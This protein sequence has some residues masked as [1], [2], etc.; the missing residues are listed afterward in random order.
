MNSSSVAAGT[1]AGK[2][3]QGAPV[4]DQP[5]SNLEAAEEKE[6]D[7]DDDDD[8]DGDADGDDDAED[9]KDEGDSKELEGESKPNAEGLE[10]DK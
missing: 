8:G 9:D 4:R 7:A 2:T 3:P 10:A 1:L 6:A 5:S